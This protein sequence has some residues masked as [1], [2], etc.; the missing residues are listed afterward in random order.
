MHDA[1]PSTIY[2]EAAKT[3]TNRRAPF[4]RGDISAQ[5]KLRQCNLDHEGT[6]A[7]ELSR[8]AIA[9]GSV[10]RLVLVGMPCIL[11]ERSPMLLIAAFFLHRPRTIRAPSPASNSSESSRAV[12]C[13]VAAVLAAVIPLVFLCGCQATPRAE[14]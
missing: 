3:E 11:P 6:P 2:T 14:R 8:R 12:A 9:E 5:L 13:R 10:A 7:A 1:F 4:G